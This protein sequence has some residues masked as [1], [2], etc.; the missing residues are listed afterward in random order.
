M[1]EKNIK[2]TGKVF[3]SYTVK[4]IE[5]MILVSEKGIK[6]KR[7]KSSSKLKREVTLWV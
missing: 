3:N 5:Q 2:S 7:F 4:E 1:K 6:N